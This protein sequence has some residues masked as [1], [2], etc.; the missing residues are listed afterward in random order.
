M[1]AHEYGEG[2]TG[3]GLQDAIVILKVLAGMDTGDLPE[4]LDRNADSLIGVSDAIWI[5][6]EV[7]A[8][9]TN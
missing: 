1:G 2:G 8:L 5:L 4:N 6:Q 7:S 9:R 3:T